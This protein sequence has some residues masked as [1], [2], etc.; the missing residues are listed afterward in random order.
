MLY[1]WS[2]LKLIVW[3]GQDLAHQEEDTLAVGAEV[4]QDAEVFHTGDPA[5][6]VHTWEKMQVHHQEGQG[7]VTVQ[8]EGTEVVVTTD[9]RKNIWKMFN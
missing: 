3:S 8:I 5:V 6:E 7:A 9:N 1:F 4:P 2:S